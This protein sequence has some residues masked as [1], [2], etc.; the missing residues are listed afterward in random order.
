MHHYD[1]ALGILL[2]HCWNV[3][4]LLGYLEECVCFSCLILKAVNS[5]LPLKVKWGR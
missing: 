2:L 1:G 5:L 4:G 3:Q